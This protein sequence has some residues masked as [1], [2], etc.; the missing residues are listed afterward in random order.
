MWETVYIWLVWLVVLYCVKRVYLCRF[1][2]RV[3]RAERARLAF[4]VFP[5]WGAR[6]TFGYSRSDQRWPIG[7]AFFCVGS[8]NFSPWLD[9]RFFFSLPPPIS[10]WL[11]C[12]A[13]ADSTGALDREGMRVG[14]PF[15]PKAHSWR[16]CGDGRRGVRCCWDG[17][18]IQGRERDGRLPLRDEPTS[19]RIK[20]QVGETDED[21]VG[22]GRTDGRLDRD[23][24]IERKGWEG[25]P[26]CWLEHMWSSTTGTIVYGPHTHTQTP[27]KLHTRQ[28]WHHPKVNRCW[29]PLTGWNV[30]LSILIV[31]IIPGPFSTLLLGVDDLRVHKTTRA[32]YTYTTRT[33]RRDPT[34]RRSIL[35]YK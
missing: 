31:I 33:Y 19:E 22:T 25:H 4:W 24:C 21:Q 9:F 8:D 16:W 34:L 14:A 11:A 28:S 23:V 10:G 27:G 2:R 32:T 17:L 20:R 1:I 6:L 12:R 13:G 15:F 30:F 26:S 5:S 7:C 29:T 3:E 35:D 18:H